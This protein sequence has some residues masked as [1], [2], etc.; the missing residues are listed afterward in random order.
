MRRCLILALLPASLALAGEWPKQLTAYRGRTPVID[1]VLD[2]GEWADATHFT[3]VRDWKP[4]FSQT[5]DDQDLSIE[6]WVKHDGENLYFAFRVTDDVLYGLDTE[7]WLPKENPKTHQL[8]REGFPWFGDEMELLINATNQW[9]AKDGE[10][11]AGNGQSW[12]MVCNLTKSRLGGIGVGGLLE[13][14]PRSVKAAWDTYQQWIL[15]GDQVAAAKVEPEPV[16]V[17]SALPGLVFGRVR[18]PGGH[19]VIEWMVKAKL[20]LEVRPG[21][22]WSPALG[23][24]KMGL[25][26]ALGD[27]DTRAAGKG[28]AFGFNHED[29]WAGERNK[30]TWLKQY[31][32]LILEPG[33]RPK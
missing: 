12:Q 18:R 19:Y 30:R 16:E 6:G 20:C 21:V 26:I 7:R 22:F 23:S 8:T 3:G 28:N 11:A 4:Q 13:G 31:G 25:N 24:V 15:H 14:E 29:W 5:T 33:P 2:R 27:I 9:S 17:I 32:T 1:G 10:N